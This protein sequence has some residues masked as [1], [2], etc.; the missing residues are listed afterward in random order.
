MQ[1]IPTARE[2]F[3]TGQPTQKPGL[4]LAPLT[5]RPQG[6]MHAFM[7]AIVFLKSILIREFNSLI[8]PSSFPIRFA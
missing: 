1:Q 5:G 7:A 8:R 2:L 4:S 6:Q 3:R